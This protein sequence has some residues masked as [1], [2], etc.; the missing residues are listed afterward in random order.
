MAT[1]QKT[2]NRRTYFYGFSEDGKKQQQR[3]V[4]RFDATV[5]IKT[6]RGFKLSKK[7]YF[8]VKL[9][10]QM[11]DN[12]TQN[13]DSLTNAWLKEKRKE[14]N[15]NSGDVVNGSDIKK[16]ILFI[17]LNYNKLFEFGMNT[18]GNYTIKHV[19]YVENLTEFKFINV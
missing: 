14:G 6:D 3:Q 5:K 9:L 18:K 7:Q 10:D 16:A 12:C 13:L 11:P 17:Y 15:F 4:M 8:I 2:E 19:P 1:T